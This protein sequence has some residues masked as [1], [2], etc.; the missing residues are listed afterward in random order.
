MSTPVITTQFLKDLAAKDDAELAVLVA[1]DPSIFRT[2][3]EEHRRAR[4]QVGTLNELGLARSLLHA[5]VEV[6]MRDIGSFT[7]PALG[8]KLRTYND[9]LKTWLDG[10][11]RFLEDHERVTVATA[12]GI[13]RD[14]RRLRVLFHDGVTDRVAIDMGVLELDTFAEAGG[15][16]YWV[17]QRG[18]AQAPLDPTRR[19][20]GARPKDGPR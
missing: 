17:W 7:D 12:I 8:Q 20:E 11:R 5:G 1:A 15:P 3:L 10:V 4:D 9:D 6:A 14:G 13:R 2:I 16:H 18:M 19:S